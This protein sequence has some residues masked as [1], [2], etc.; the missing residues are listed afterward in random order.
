VVIRKV[1]GDTYIIETSFQTIPFVRIEGGKIIMIDCGL[2]E[3]RE[4]ILNLLDS[5]GLKPAAVLAT[6]AHVDHIGNAAYFQKEFGAKIIMNE[7]EAAVANSVRGL[8]T[9]YSTLSV[10]DIMKHFGNMVVEA[11]EKFGMHEDHVEV[12]GAEFGIIASPGHS[13]GHIAVLTPDNVACIGD[14]LASCDVLGGSRMMYSFAISKDLESKKSLMD[15][16][17][18]K[19]IL[20]HKGAFDEIRSIIPANIKYFEDSA[21]EVLNLIDTP[22]GFEEL[23][24]RVI[25]LKGTKVASLYKY[26]RMERMTR[27]LLEYLIDTGRLRC[28]IIDSRLY[29]VK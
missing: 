29:Y 25:R 14:A 23:L 20:S 5:E 21:E 2:V 7:V 18:D 22:V 3:E 12:L 13:P 17:A 1:K 16:E 9:T 27:P 19:F 8:K 24:D 4:G 28:T 11:D 6:H 26:N 10:T 15:I